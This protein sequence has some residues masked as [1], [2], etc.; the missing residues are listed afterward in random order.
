MIDYDKASDEINALFFAAW[1]DKAPAIV[2]YVPEVRWFG[3]EDS[4]LPDGSKFWARVSKQTVME[5]QTSLSTCVGEPGKRRYTASGLVF[6]QLFC[7]KSVDKA[8]ELGERLAVVARNAFRG[9]TTPGKIWFRN[10]RINEIPPESLYF[11]FNIVAEFE[12]TEN[13]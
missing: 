11:R 6:V 7:P 10:V 12:Y 8:C 13:G 4:D 3:V 1:K 5:E 2:G 9:K